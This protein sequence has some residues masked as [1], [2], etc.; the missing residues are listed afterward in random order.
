MFTGIAYP[1]VSPIITN[2]ITVKTIKELKQWFYPKKN[3]FKFEEED[4]D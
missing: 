1:D 4:I 2:D 3:I